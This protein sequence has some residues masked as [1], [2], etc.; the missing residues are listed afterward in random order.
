MNLLIVV[1]LCVI[2]NVDLYVPVL[3][4]S[5]QPDD[6]GELISNFIVS[7]RVLSILNFINE[8]CRG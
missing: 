8:K 1:S 3:N 7:L 5:L 2:S 6:E 4:C